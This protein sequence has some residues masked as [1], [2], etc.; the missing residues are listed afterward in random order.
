MALRA[1]WG[2]PPRCYSLVIPSW[3]EALE[4][5]TAVL[6]A[7][8]PEPAEARQQ[9]EKQKQQVY[10]KMVHGRYIGRQRGSSK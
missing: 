3:T 4:E 6:K 9:R 8:D 7:F 1:S 10:P 2:E 5:A